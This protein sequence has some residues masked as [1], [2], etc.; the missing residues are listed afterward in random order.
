MSIFY[1][2]RFGLIAP[3]LAVLGIAATGASIDGE[4][5]ANGAAA[6]KCSI[7]VE[8]L[9]DAVELKALISSPRK[10]SGSYR[11]TVTTSGGGNSSAINQSGGFTAGG[12]GA[13]VISRVML[14][15]DGN[16]TARLSITADGRTVECRERVGGSI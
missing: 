11:L 3:A 6:L 8:R 15:G 4:A 5:L 9:G 1:V 10:A 13:E 16:F 2:T 7:A 12:R 14:G